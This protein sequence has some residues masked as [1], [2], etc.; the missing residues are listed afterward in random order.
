[1]SIHRPVTGYRP[2]EPP[3]R[4]TRDEIMR[5]NKLEQYSEKAQI[6]QHHNRHQHFAVGTR[7]AFGWIAF[8]GLVVAGGSAT[9]VALNRPW[10]Q[11]KLSEDK[12]VST[13]DPN[14]PVPNDKLSE[15]ILLNGS[16]ASLKVCGDYREADGTLTHNTIATLD[17]QGHLKK[18]QVTAL[19]N[20]AISVGLGQK[21]VGMSPEGGW[22]GSDGKLHENPIDCSTVLA[23]ADR[24]KASDGSTKIHLIPKELLKGAMVKGPLQQ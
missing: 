16:K 14:A 18:A 13:T 12:P 15:V 6:A 3:K 23:E 7:N 9:A 4:L 8:F 2:P 11:V 5:N 17:N 21:P 10:D 20:T 19:G 1:M 24:Y 22:V